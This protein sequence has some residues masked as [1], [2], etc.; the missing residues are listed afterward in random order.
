MTAGPRKE[1]QRERDTQTMSTTTPGH[2]SLRCLG[3]GW[4]LRLKLQRSFP[5]RTLGFGSGHDDSLRARE[6]ST[7]PEGTQEEGWACR[8]TIAVK[9]RGRGKDH[10]RNI[11][12]CASTGS[13]VE[14]HLLLRQRA[15]GVNHHSHLSLERWV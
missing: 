5:V 13:W 9:I 8:G 4:V 12:L 10:H 1:K 11:F 15:A 2:H 6:W 7:I 14:G 3:M